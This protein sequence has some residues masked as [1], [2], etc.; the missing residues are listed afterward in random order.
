MGRG[1]GWSKE[2]DNLVRKCAGMMS[3]ES[4]AERLEGRSALSV[5]LYMHRNGIPTRRVLARPIVKLMIQIKF[6]DENWF[7]P[8]KS[9]YQ[10]VGIGQQR[11]QNLSKGYDQP[12]QDELIRISRVLNMQLDEML[13]MQEATQLD[14]FE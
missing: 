4:I 2:E 14:L 12:T 6:G 8:N 1:K 3:F 7:A 5:Q 13:K 11:F 10:K 9:F